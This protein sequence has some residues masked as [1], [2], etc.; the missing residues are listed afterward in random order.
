ML[1]DLEFPAKPKRGLASKENGAILLEEIQRIKGYKRLP[2]IVMT[3][4]V[5]YGFCRTTQYLEAGAHAFIPKPFPTESHT[6][7]AVIRKVLKKRRQETHA[8]QTQGDSSTP[9]RFAGGELAFF[10]DRVE[11]DGVKI[12][13]NR[14]TGQCMMVLEELRRRD[15]TGRYVRLSADELANAVGAMAGVT[16]ITGCVRVLRRNIVTRLP[17][18]LNIEVGPEDVIAHDE[19]G[20]FLRDWIS[21]RDA[22]DASQM[23]KVV[24][25]PADELSRGGDEVN[26]NERQ[27]WVLRELQRGTQVRRPMLESKFDVSDKTAKRDLAQLIS[28]GAVAFVHAG[29]DGYYQLAKAG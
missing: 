3:G 5:A 11:L 29:R 15:S 7:P 4:H 21:V 28:R 19:Q 9:S 17:K 8:S 13:A 14:G 24:A 1:L 18:N 16:T 10:D 12:I 20:Y 22:R 2:V 6:L 23:D 26:L 27:Q 25:A